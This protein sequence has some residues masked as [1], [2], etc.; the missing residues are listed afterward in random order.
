MRII[1]YTGKGGVGKT[2]VAAATA[3]C[4][5]E[6]GYRTIVLS[7]DAAHSLADSFDIPLGADP[8][9]I[10]PNL[11]GQEVNIYHEIEEHW[12]TIQSYLATLLAWR[13]LEEIVAEEM[14]VL[15][16]MEELSSLLLITDHHDSGQYDVII[17][18][19]A[20]TGE[21]LRLLTFPEVARWWLEKILPIQRQAYKLIR[22]VVRTISDIPLPAD[23]VFGAIE[24]LFGKL[25]TMRCLLIDR[26]K[27]SIRLVLNAEK[28]VIK[29]AQ[30]TFTYLNLYSYPTDAII[31]NRV[32]PQ[33]VSDAHFEDW[34]DIQ[35]R[36]RNLIE[37]SFAPLPIL[38][39][40]LFRSEVLG[41]RMLHDMALAL[42]GHDDPSKIYFQGQTHTV[43]RVD[44]GYILRIILPFVT[45]EEVE[46]TRS[47]DELIARIGNQKRNLTLPRAL[48]SLETKEAK[49]EDNVLKVTFVDGSAR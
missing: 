47:G 31:C 26:N 6:M 15:P 29:E 36:Y 23:D 5:A 33:S 44:G 16:G 7:T 42:F 46:L 2:T 3:L 32:I 10:I 20:P 48:I 25:D 30:R 28:M 24:D 1:L 40:P 37:E 34:K 27:S 38:S 19:C 22:P 12:G 21:T 4:C 17:V 45:K 14:T 49:L 41:Q 8:T 39:A 11:W 35:G 18:D 13:G 9:P 43:E